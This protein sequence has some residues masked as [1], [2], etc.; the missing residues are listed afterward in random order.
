[1]ELK[2]CSAVEQ[3]LVNGKIVDGL[4]LIDMKDEPELF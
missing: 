2:S 3:H 1:L 4:A